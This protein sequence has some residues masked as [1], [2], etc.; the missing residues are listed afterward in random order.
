MIGR[1]ARASCVLDRRCA[2]FRGYDSD[3]TR[4]FSVSG[5]FRP[6]QARAV[7]ARAPAPCLTAIERCA[8]GIEWRDVHRTAALVLAEGLVSLR[9]AARRRPTN[10]VEQRAA[11]VSAATSLWWRSS[12]GGEPCR[13]QSPLSRRLTAPLRVRPPIAVV[14]DWR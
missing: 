4:T 9:P 8:P 3:I 1:S 11:H 6:E 10:L 14:T 5:R 12:S 13:T 2:E 7:R